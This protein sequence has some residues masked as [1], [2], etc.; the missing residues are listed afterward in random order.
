MAADLLARRRGSGR[1]G[2]T[3]ASPEIQ[4]SICRAR[5]E[6][7]QVANA[8]I[9]SPNCRAGRTLGRELVFAGEVAFDFERGKCMGEGGPAGAAT[10][11]FAME[12]SFRWCTGRTKRD[13]MGRV[14]AIRSKRTEAVDKPQSYRLRIKYVKNEVAVYLG[15]MT[16]A[17]DLQ[18][19]M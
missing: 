18:S 11:A 14:S 12:R 3:G 6:G 9:R 16:T 4:E 13:R 15:M 8:R 19:K 10:P 7:E 1:L 5:R 17:F 2:V